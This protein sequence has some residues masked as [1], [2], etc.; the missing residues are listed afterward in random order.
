M[1]KI[2]KKISEEKQKTYIEKQ[3]FGLISALYLN[4]KKDK[5]W[6]TKK[7]GGKL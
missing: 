3:N 1:P 2:E 5:T 7:K 4:D 6:I